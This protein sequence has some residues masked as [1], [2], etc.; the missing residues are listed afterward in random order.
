[1]LVDFD[2]RG[3]QVLTFFTGGHYFGLSTHILA[4]SNSL[5]LKCLKMIVHPIYSASSSSLTGMNFF[6]LPNTKE[7][8]LNKVCN[9]AVL[10]LH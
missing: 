9:Q 1:M 8:I 2:V 4:K 5:N 7:D 10:G 3:K 6:V